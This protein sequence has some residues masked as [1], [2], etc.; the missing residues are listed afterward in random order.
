LAIIGQIINKWQLF[1]EIQDGGGPHL[2]FWLLRFFDV[3]YFKVAILLLTLVMI[4][5]IVK[6][7]QPFFEIQDGGDPISI[8][9]LFISDVIYMFQIEVP[10]SSTILATIG[11]MVNEWQK[12]FEIQYGGGRHLELWLL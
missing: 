7:W 2:E 12:F 10:M 11:Q 4:G 6:K 8:L 5:Q 9:K 1:F 3:A